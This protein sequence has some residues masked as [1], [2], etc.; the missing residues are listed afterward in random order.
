[1]DLRSK[2]IVFPTK[3]E[4]IVSKYSDG[5][6]KR[7]KKVFGPFS[8]VGNALPSMASRKEVI[9]LGDGLYAARISCLKHDP[10]RGRR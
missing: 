8:E 7:D 9:D 1:M 10:N 2:E 5:L 6:H 3:R 4:V